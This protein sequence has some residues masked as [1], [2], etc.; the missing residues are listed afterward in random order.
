[1]NTTQ[2]IAVQA[3]IL[4][5]VGTGA[6]AYGTWDLLPWWSYP[7]AFVIMWSYLYNA[8]VKDAAREKMANMMNRQ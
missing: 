5:V 8:W 4:A 1:M 7:I 2:R 6:F 3:T